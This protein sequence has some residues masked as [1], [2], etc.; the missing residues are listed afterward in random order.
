MKNTPPSP[1]TPPRNKGR[2]P[3]TSVLGIPMPNELKEKIAQA[4]ALEHRKMADWARLELEEIA[5]A[6]I[7]A[8]Q[9]K[10]IMAVAEEHHAAVIQDSHIVP[11]RRNRINY[12]TV[13]KSK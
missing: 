9:P 7:A 2:A 13:K 12:R 8:Y 6:I 4:A 1:A 10:Q 3:G 11:V 5:D